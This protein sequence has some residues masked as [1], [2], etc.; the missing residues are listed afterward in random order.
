M[1]LLRLE[2][3]NWV[4]HRYRVCEFS[5]GLV[6]ILGE[7]GSGKSSL[8]GAI[9]WL[10]TGENPNYGV[11][12][13]NVSQYAKEGE[14]SYATL[15]F[16][17]NGHM[18]VVT[19][20]LLPEKEQSILTVD[21]KEAGR[22]DKAV[23][24]GIEKLLGVDAKFISRFIIV[25]QTEIFSF[26]DENQTD[27]DKFFQRLFNTAK[28]DKCQD[29]I[30][31]ALAKI[32]IPE[33]VQT[34]VVLQA[35]LEE[36]HGKAAKLA[37]AI[38]KLP[39]LESFLEAQNA[40]QATIQQWEQREK[41]GQE[42]TKLAEQESDLQKQ[43][44]AA[45][46]A[47]K[48]YEDDL[49]A[50]TSAA[51]GQEE[52]YAAA[53]TALGHW[54]SYKRVAK[55][56]ETIQETRQAIET[57]RASDPEP[58]K[59]GPLS[60]VD[61]AKEASSR[62]KRIRE[63]KEFIRM[64][65]EHGV[66]ECP[67]CHTPS[68]QLT[69]QVAA[70]KAE[71]TKL[72]KEVEGL[73]MAF[74]GELKIENF[75]K[76]WDNREKDRLK[77]EQ[78]LDAAEQSLQAIPAPAATE[79]ELQQAVGDYEQ[80]QQVKQEIMPLAQQAREKKAKLVG[81]LTGIKDRRR[82]LEENIKTATVTKADAHLAQHNLTQRKELLKTRVA[83]SDERS[84]LLFDMKRLEEQRNLAE[85][86]T[87]MAVKLRS[88]TGVAESAREALKNAPRLV[89]QRNLQ[90]LESA[91]NELLQIFRVNFVVKV[92]TD[93]TPTFIAEF[94]DGRRQVAQR[95]SIGQKTVLALAFRVAVNAM[96]AEEIGLLALDEPTASLD[97]PRIQALAPVL[98]KLR[99]LSTAK[100]LQC[101][102]VT[103]AANLS[104]LFESTI[105]LEAPELRHG[106]RAG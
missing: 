5:R 71:L 47:G 90:R 9:R 30:G 33:V 88:W 26:I 37:A 85:Q 79:D 67:T 58:D 35:Q 31:K 104:H 73:T 94:F 72:V 22:G 49:T 103:H 15:E 69:E 61:L 70:H 8:F 95:L 53:R 100:G 106:T 24:A 64:F 23:T 62:E 76:D 77:H 55:S 6:A 3:K 50:L 63:I 42:L 46:A 57:A 105:E 92:A 87:Q 75:W 80:F 89:A 12:A 51:D 102:L 25:S 68:T 81:L 18:A 43:F 1:Q 52:A 20:H 66:A 82:Q 86:Q 45:E 27:T 56:R 91:I 38:A 97:Q 99:D 40:D 83:L 16:E 14:P 78:K 54:E 7:N 36:L 84:Q 11:K 34:P 59:P 65:D 21:G 96:F 29:V 2:V 4:H 41:D 17:H 39:T 10:L 13:D 44:D 101:L 98:E 28:A 19:R 93:G 32:S 74:H 60:S 48:Q